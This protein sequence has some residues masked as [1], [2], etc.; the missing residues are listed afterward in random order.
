MYYMFGD[1]QRVLHQDEVEFSKY[2]FEVADVQCF[3]ATRGRR[4]VGTIAATVALV[5]ILRDAVVE[6]I[7]AL[8]AGSSPFGGFSQTRFRLK[9]G[10]RTACQTSVAERLRCPTR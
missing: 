10:L 2:Y 7:L 1:G 5:P 9:A 6:P 8:A 4:P 3:L